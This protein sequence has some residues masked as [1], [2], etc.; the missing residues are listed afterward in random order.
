MKELK[1]VDKLEDLSLY[2][3]LRDILKI[4]SKASKLAKLENKK[5][6]IPKIFVRND[7]IYYEFENGDITTKRPTILE[8]EI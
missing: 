2:I 5:Y 3:E 1:E 7:I 4:G 6:G 8:K